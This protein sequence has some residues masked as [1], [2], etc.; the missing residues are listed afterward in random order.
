MDMRRAAGI[1]HRHDGAEGELAGGV[2]DRMA[3]TLEP[4][5]AEIEIVAAAMQVDAVGVALPDLDA[6]ARRY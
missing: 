3:E 4:A 6:Q 1:G 5:V 2:G